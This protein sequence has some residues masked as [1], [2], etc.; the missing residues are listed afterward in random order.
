METARRG[1]E[2]LSASPPSL[3]SGGQTSSPIRSEVHRMTS[4]RALRKKRGMKQ[5]DLAQAAG[6]SRNVVRNG[7]CGLS[8]SP[9]AVKALADALGVDVSEI[10]DFTR[11]HPLRLWRYRHGL[12]Q[13][14][15]ARKLRISD[16]AVRRWESGARGISAKHLKALAELFGCATKDLQK[17]GCH[18]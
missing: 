7:E 15:L 4:I 5:K 11:D 3:V 17:D 8:I 9:H 16:D 18:G 13:I 2:P 6:V 1:P 14:E 12:T 10:S